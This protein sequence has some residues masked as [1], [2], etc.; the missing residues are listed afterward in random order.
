MGRRLRTQLPVLPSTLVP[1]NLLRERKDVAKKGEIYRSNQKG[2]FDCRHQ[3]HELPDLT[4]GDSVWIRDQD[5]L[6]TIRGRTQH[7]RSYLIETEKGTMRRN[8]SALVKAESHSTPVV[9]DDAATLTS[10]VSV[11]PV[12]DSKAQC[13]GALQSPVFHRKLTKNSLFAENQQQYKHVQEGLSDLLADWTCS[14]L[15][16]LSV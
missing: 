13:A 2:N 7:P 4:T 1:R 14:F 12:V 8:R 6:G 3:A 5:R 10:P 15:R 11:Q 9:A 16:A